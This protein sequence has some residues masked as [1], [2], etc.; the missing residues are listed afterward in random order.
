MVGS[1]TIGSVPDRDRCTIPGRWELG[2]FLGVRGWRDFVRGSMYQGEWWGQFW[3]I[4][5]GIFMG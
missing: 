1:G 4:T 3:Y 2:L 5:L